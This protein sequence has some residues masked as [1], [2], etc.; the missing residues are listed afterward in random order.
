MEP[1]FAELFPE[2]LLGL[3]PVEFA[4]IAARALTPRRPPTVSTDHIHAPF[5]SVREQA[6]RLADKL[7]RVHRASFRA[8]TTECTAT[9]EVVACFLALLELFREDRVALEQ[10]APLGDIYVTWNAARAD[11][12]DAADDEAGD[13][14]DDWDTAIPPGAGDD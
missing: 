1:R 10:L 6:R 4:R 8:L 11:D 13:I 12:R 9:Q 5:V 14:T 3:G 2:V 7:R